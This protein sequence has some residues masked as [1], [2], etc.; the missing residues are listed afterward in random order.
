VIRVSALAS[1]AALAAAIP[2]AA[3][4]PAAARPTPVAAAASPLA[5]PATNDVSSLVRTA[6]VPVSPTDSAG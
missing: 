5:E 2:A 3:A 1:A 6:M 4:L